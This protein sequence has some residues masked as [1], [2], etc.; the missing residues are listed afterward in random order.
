MSSIGMSRRGFLASSGCL[1]ASRAAAGAKWDLRRRAHVLADTLFAGSGLADGGIM[2]P[3]N[4]LEALAPLVPAARGQAAAVLNILYSGAETSA[5]PLAEASDLW[6]ALAPDTDA[7]RRSPLSH[8]AALWLD[9]T[10]TTQPRTSRMWQDP[11]GVLVESLAL[12]S[13]AALSRI[14]AWVGRQTAGLVPSVLDRIPSGASAIVTAALHFAASWGRAF[15]PALTRP[16]LFTPPNGAPIMVPFMRL[17]APMPVDYAE[18]NGLAGVRLAY[19]D[20]A[21][22]YVTVI[23]CRGADPGLV[24]ALAA[25]GSLLETVDRM[26]FGPRLD[27]ELAF[28]RLAMSWSVDL[29]PI[30]RSGPLAA[31]FGPDAAFGP[32]FDGRS[33]IAMIQSRTAL[34]VDEAGTEAAAT[35][36]V[37]ME[38]SMTTEGTLFRADLPFLAAVRHRASG[39][40]VIAALVTDPTA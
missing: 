30:L 21:F 7:N 19:A 8:A 28:P 29:L 12:D 35:A 20:P 1:A 32:P 22:E 10:A 36:T 4:I 27:V 9:E 3:L 13:P 24:P 25:R 16:G 34:R 39:M 17:A 18:A 15:D 38:R 2:S 40:F 26:I 11:L 33:R 31:A 14:N 6:S 23:R 5:D 37:A